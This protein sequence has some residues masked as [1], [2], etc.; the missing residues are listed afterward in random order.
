MLQFVNRSPSAFPFLTREAAEGMLSNVPQPG[1]MGVFRLS[2]TIPLTLVFRTHIPNPKFDTNPQTEPKYLEFAVAEEVWMKWIKVYPFKRDNELYVTAAMQY[3]IRTGVNRLS[4]HGIRNMILLSDIRYIKKI[5]QA[6]RGAEGGYDPIEQVAFYFTDVER[7]VDSVVKSGFKIGHTDNRW[8][9]ITAQTI[10]LNKTSF[11]QSTGDR[12]PDGTFGRAYKFGRGRPKSTTGKNIGEVVAQY[13]MGSFTGEF[14]CVDPIKEPYWMISSQPYMD[15]K[16]LDKMYKQYKQSNY[17]TNYIKAVIDVWDILGSWMKH[18]PW[19]IHGYR[20]NRN[21][22]ILISWLGP[23][24][25]GYLL[26]ISP[27]ENGWRD[28]IP[29]SVKDRRSWMILNC[30]YELLTMP[31]FYPFLNPYEQE[32]MAFSHP[33]HA[34]LTLDFNQPGAVNVYRVDPYV[35]H[36][37]I[38]GDPT[39][40]LSI[41]IVE[42][43]ELLPPE[44]AL[45]IPTPLL[46]ELVVLRT[47]GHRLVYTDVPAKIDAKMCDRPPVLTDRYQTIAEQWIDRISFT[48]DIRGSV[49]SQ[50]IEL[51]VSGSRPMDK[52][53]NGSFIERIQE[54]GKEIGKETG[55]LSRIAQRVKN[56]FNRGNTQ[57]GWSSTNNLFG[58]DI[59]DAKRVTTFIKDILEQ[60]YIP[61]VT[62]D[63]KTSRPARVKLDKLKIKSNEMEVLAFPPEPGF[64]AQF[65]IEQA[66]EYQKQFPGWHLFS[67]GD[68]R[69]LGLD[70]MVELRDTSWTGRVKDKLIKTFKGHDRKDI[71][72]AMSE[73]DNDYVTTAI[74]RKIRKKEPLGDRESVFAMKHN[75]IASVQST[76]NRVSEA[77]RSTVKSTASRVSEATRSAVQNVVIPGVK[78][79]AESNEY[80]SRIPEDNTLSFLNTNTRDEYQSEEAY[81]TTIQSAGFEKLG[82]STNTTHTFPAFGIEDNKVVARCGKKNWMSQAKFPTQR[83]IDGIDDANRR[84]ID[85]LANLARHWDLSLERKV[86]LWRWVGV[87][88][89]GKTALNILAEA[90]LAQV[91]HDQATYK[92]PVTAVAAASQA[93]RRIMLHELTSQVKQSKTVDIGAERICERRVGFLIQ[94]MS[95]P[96]LFPFVVDEVEARKIASHHL[97]LVIVMLDWS[98]SGGLQFYRTPSNRSS[99]Q[100]HT[101]NVETLFTK[102]QYYPVATRL[103]AFQ[104][105]AGGVLATNELYFRQ[106]RG[107]RSSE[108]TLKFVGVRSTLPGTYHPAFDKLMAE[109]DSIK[110]MQNVPEEQKQALIA[111]FTR[112]EKMSTTFQS[113]NLTTQEQPI[114]EFLHR[115][116]KKRLTNLETYRQA[117]EMYGQLNTVTDEVEIRQQ[118]ILNM[119]QNP[120]AVNYMRRKYKRMY[121]KKPM[122]EIESMSRDNLCK[123]MLNNDNIHQW[124]QTLKIWDLKNVPDTLQDKA[125]CLIRLWDDDPGTVSRVSDWLLKHYGVSLQEMRGFNS[126]EKDDAKLLY[127]MGQKVT[128]L[129]HESRSVSTKKQLHLLQFKT[130]LTEG[131][132]CSGVSEEECARAMV[133]GDEQSCRWSDNRCQRGKIKALS[134]LEQIVGSFCAHNVQLLENDWEFITGTYETL[135]IYFRMTQKPGYEK[136]V[137]TSHLRADNSD[138]MCRRNIAMLTVL[139]QDAAQASLDAMDLDIAEFF[140]ND[141]I[142]QLNEAYQLF[143]T[144]QHPVVPKIRTE[145]LESTLS[146][147][148]GTQP[149]IAQIIN[150][151]ILILFYIGCRNGIMTIPVSLR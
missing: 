70:W 80:I 55:I 74:N 59:L 122:E 27:T 35:R 121:P 144:T 40:H 28:T 137:D 56:Y 99:T 54:I 108:R 30:F 4:Q 136:G 41:P 26:Q 37:H 104:M 66:T 62:S 36:V 46:L 15:K 135:F 123:S 20:G 83:E 25:I 109:R 24:T 68:E 49:A 118:L 51:L 67:E 5:M 18:S 52:L 89:L 61:A 14:D 33:G 147:F 85:N 48:N 78:H 124:K 113:R 114:I 103:A 84:L 79:P 93:S 129:E 110:R 150:F 141:Q 63:I 94:M 69:D 105:F 22:T 90:T 86:R 143:D 91:G 146:R 132:E 42:L 138:H 71:V 95:S 130:F 87:G 116:V 58:L 43:Y 2:D 100:I 32:G 45:A 96:I 19:C 21:R 60:E 44:Q 72:A 119:C 125:T 6:C 131:M 127:D 88:C 7:E 16:I 111:R 12:C 134:L 117:S 1:S 8:D 57:R 39:G 3:Y 97:D 65:N 77:I 34:V 139:A 10:N 76:T 112:F 23:E 142:I 38:S 145:H 98:R 128:K 73:G 64:F 13:T 107:K 140:I 101:R 120:E 106:I 75:L 151:T 82:C 149:T 50:L 53:L 81:F 9:K 47:Y 133:I 17:P 115:L 29:E 148:A 31:G 92:S 11:V 102:H 126:A